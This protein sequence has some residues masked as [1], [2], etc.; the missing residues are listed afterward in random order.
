VGVRAVGSQTSLAARA[1]EL[2][3]ALARV[4]RLRGLLPIC[5]YCEKIRNDQNYWQQL[6]NYIGERSEA[7]FSDGI[8]PDCFEKF[9]RPE[10]EKL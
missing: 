1:A 4:K 10:L 9:A 8:R 7:R 3:E 6:E 5:S 2:E